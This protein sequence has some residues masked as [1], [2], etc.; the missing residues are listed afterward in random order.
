[1]V[2]LGRLIEHGM[3]PLTYSSKKAGPGEIAQREE[4]RQV[5]VDPKFSI[6]TFHEWFCNCM[7]EN[8]WLN[9]LKPL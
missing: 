8:A 5:R 9:S 6:C 3:A 7:V 4:A 2:F 1:M